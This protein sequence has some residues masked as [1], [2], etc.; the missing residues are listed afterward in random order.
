MRAAQTHRD[1]IIQ[2]FGERTI[3]RSR[4]FT[5][6]DITATALARL[7]PKKLHISALKSQIVANLRKRTHLMLRNL[8][9]EFKLKAA[10]FDR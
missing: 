10:Y 1:R 3:M 9:D 7:N 8:M 5:Q 4:E 2:L 6:E